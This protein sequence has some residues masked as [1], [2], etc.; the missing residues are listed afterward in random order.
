MK[1]TGSGSRIAARIR[2]ARALRGP[3]GMTT[4]TPGKWAQ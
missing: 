1:T 2:S 4:F 3:D